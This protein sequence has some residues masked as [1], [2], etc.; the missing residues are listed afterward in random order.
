MQVLNLEKTTRKIDFSSDNLEG[1]YLTGPCNLEIREN[2]IVVNVGLKEIDVLEEPVK[3]IAPMKSSMLR[4]TVVRSEDAM[5]VVILKS[6][7]NIGSVILNE[8][9]K[10]AEEIFGDA[11]KGV[12]LWRSPQIELGEIRFNPGEITKSENH[13]E[14]PTVRFKVIIN[15]WYATAD[16]HCAIH[17]KHSFIEYHTQIMGY[18][19]MQKFK[20]N[21]FDTLY[22]D[23]KLSE[24]NTHDLFCI[25]TPD[26]QFVYPWHQYY[27]DTD[28]IWL[29]TE[30]HPVLPV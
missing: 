10:P 22:E 16:T 4:D 26:I 5:L 7:A 27:A 17:N 28:C 13:C 11:L 30:L 3:S 15:L 12:P 18:G 29:V 23:I 20:E 21:S 2:A 8:N 19:R 25:T 24:G 1:Y 14:I 9:W 6:T